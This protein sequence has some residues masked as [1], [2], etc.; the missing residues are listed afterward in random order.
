M[1]RT[2]I[3]SLA[4]AGL[5]AVAL[6]GCGQQSSPPPPPPPPPAAQ[7]P[8]PATPAPAAPAGPSLE[9]TQHLKQGMAYVSTAKNANSPAIFNENINNA[10]NEFSNA[11]KKDPG[12]ATAYS[13]RAVAYMMQKKYNLAL[14]D[15]KKAKELKPSDPAVRYNT[16]ACHSL[17]GNVDLAFVELDAALANGFN[18][19]DSLRKDPDLANM[20]KHPDWRKTLEKYKVFIN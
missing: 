17:M 5:I 6:I 9:V 3:A 13:N 18:D 4:L 7:A 15:L 19:Y 11:I 10:I 20:R 1:K 8:A 16:A 2:I 12:Y 14:D